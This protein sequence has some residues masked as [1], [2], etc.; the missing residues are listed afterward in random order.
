[1]YTEFLLTA[2]TKYKQ[3]KCNRD[4]FIVSLLQ[5]L[6]GF[7]CYKNYENWGSLLLQVKTK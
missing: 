7:I 4:F 2:Y 1:M 3:V 5:T 6:Q